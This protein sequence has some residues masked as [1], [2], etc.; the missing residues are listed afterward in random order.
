MRGKLHGPLFCY[1]DGQPISRK[2]FCLILEAALKFAK[3]DIKKYK[4]HS[5]RIGATPTAHLFGY[6][7]SQI[8]NMGRWSSDSYRRYIRIPLLSGLKDSGTD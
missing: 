7:D 5:F 1:K 2:E 3:Y 6:M 8:Q 4:P